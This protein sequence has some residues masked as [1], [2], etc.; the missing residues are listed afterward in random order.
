MVLL[1]DK[2]K[3]D[4]FM[5]SKLCG[6]LS[7]GDLKDNH[8]Q[9]RPSGQ[10]DVTTRDNFIVTVINNEDFDSIKICEQLTDNGIVLWLID[11]LQRS[12]TI[13]AYKS[14]KFKLGKNIDPYMYEYQEL[15]KDESGKMKYQNISYDLR[16]KAYKDLPEKIKEEFDN[17][18]VMVVKHL[19][20]SDK[21]ICRHIVRYN[22]G[23][24]MS[25]AHKIVAYMHNTA[26]PIKDLSNHGFFNDCANLPV[27]AD[28][29]GTVNQIVSESVMAINFFE[30]WNKDAKKIGNHL[31]ENATEEMF[32]TFKNYL[33]RLIKIVDS[34]TGK[35]FTKKNAML[36][37]MLFDK[38]NKLG[39]DDSRFQEFLK[40]L[41]KLENKKMEVKNKYE[42]VAGEEKTN[43]VS[44]AQLNKLRAVKDKGI[45]IDKLHIL[46][47]IMNTYFENELN[48]EIITE[49]AEIEEVVSFVDSANC[50]KNTDSENVVVDS[51]N[52]M[53]LE[54]FV[55]NN[56]PDVIDDDVEFFDM[57]ANDC[58]DCL[59]ESSWI[60]DDANRS[61]YVAIVGYA[62]RE[63]REDDL[64]EWLPEFDKSK[65]LVSNQEELFFLM[66]KSFDSFGIGSVKV[67][68]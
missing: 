24:P 48:K 61:A 7:R 14:G 46:E 34:K 40:D 18:P 51:V 43:F 12:S 60:L 49:N 37:F 17:C 59:C 21:E 50:S 39:L 65:L 10:W 4:T 44:L 57:I 68:A 2:I 54:E 30:N 1:R 16:G 9:Q 66:K 41:D 52:D 33:D 56:V 13:E 15:V 47:V 67:S 19:D 6:M 23:K 53:T 58:S 55:K 38:F 25:N 45:I 64:L 26:K 42:I 62:V 3:R 35:L 5:V 8:P 27:V 31:N 63:E 36:F 11:G 28:K 29:N 22:S 20:C 32:E